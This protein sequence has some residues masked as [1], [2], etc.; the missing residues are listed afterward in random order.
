MIYKHIVDLILFITQQSMMVQSEHVLVLSSL[1]TT[2]L[3][4]IQQ[5]V[6]V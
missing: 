5:L 1:E 3:S 4:T 6:V 2:A